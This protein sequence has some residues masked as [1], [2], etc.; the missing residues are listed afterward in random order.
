MRRL[1]KKLKS[2]G[3]NRRSTWFS[4]DAGLVV[5]FLHV[6]KFTFGPCFRLHWGIRVLND[7]RAFIA[8]TGPEE[9]QGLEYGAD[10]DSLDRCAERMHRIVAGDAEAWFAKQTTERLLKA[11]S[12]LDAS[13]RSA[14]QRALA[15]QVDQEAVM[16]SRELLGI[17]QAGGN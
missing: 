14:L 1:A 7:S 9:T 4:R 13:A 6:H 15:G 16:R 2:R 8:L 10:D 3:F 5:Q 17:G 12:C 11:D